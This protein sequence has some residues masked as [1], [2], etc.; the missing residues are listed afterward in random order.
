MLPQTRNQWFASSQ[1]AFEYRCPSW[2]LSCSSIRPV[3]IFLRWRCFLLFLAETTWT[4]YSLRKSQWDYAKHGPDTKCDLYSQNCRKFLWCTWTETRG[5]HRCRSCMT[6]DQR[7]SR[8][9]VTMETVHLTPLSNGNLHDCWLL[10][11]W[12]LHQRYWCAWNL[13]CRHTTCR[14][15]SWT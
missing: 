3:S 5:N 14:F 11:H 12:H 4:A 13:S 15:R 7:H 6:S 2:R 10:L 8:C 1:C 9:S